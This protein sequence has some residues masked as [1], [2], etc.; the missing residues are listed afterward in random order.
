MIRLSETRQ[1]ISGVPDTGE[2]CEAIHRVRVFGLA[3]AIMLNGFAALLRVS[4]TLDNI[5]Y[6]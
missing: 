1:T 2:L 5:A 3:A 6:I 4:P